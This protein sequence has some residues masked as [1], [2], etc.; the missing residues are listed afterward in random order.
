[1]R[2]IPKQE[3]LSDCGLYL[4]GYMEKFFQ[5]PH[6]FA[7]R[8][9]SREMVIEHDWPTFNSTRMRTIIL[10]SLR[11]LAEQ[12]A[13]ERRAAKMA[14]MKQGCEQ[15]EASSLKG[16]RSKAS[17]PEAACSTPKSK[18]AAGSRRSR[19]ST[20]KAQ[21]SARIPHGAKSEPR[22]TS[23]SPA[24]VGKRTAASEPRSSTVARRPSEES[25]P[26]RRSRRGT[27][28]LKLVT[29]SGS[30]SPAR[31]V[32]SKGHGVPDRRSREGSSENPIVLESASP[33]PSSA[34][35]TAS[36]LS[37][38]GSFENFHEH[39]RH[40]PARCTKQGDIEREGDKSRNTD[41]GSKQKRRVKKEA[42]K[43][44]QKRSID[45]DSRPEE[46]EDEE[47]HGDGSD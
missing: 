24:A 44:H 32:G 37:A 6:E 7:A 2:E 25:S 19:S 47:E 31:S 36:S 17:S 23:F 9:L 13:L 10:Q 14:Q 46:E 12:Q 45:V 22:K 29:R 18:T 8:I 28:P 35:L 41:S 40:A 15:P 38:A 43:R 30:N 26:S 21:T 39:P 20:P 11:E 1:M 3:N 33:G 16:E 5:D 34:D 27:T 42:R 4:L